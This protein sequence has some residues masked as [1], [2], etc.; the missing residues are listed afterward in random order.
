[1]SLES[2]ALSD[3]FFSIEPPGKPSF[4]LML[5][6]QPGITV[7][8]GNLVSGESEFSGSKSHLRNQLLEYL[9]L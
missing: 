9:L 1:M 3:G 6:S 2:P 8:Q 7:G 4:L 5:N